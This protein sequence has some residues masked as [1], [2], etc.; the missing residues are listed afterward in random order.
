L[1]I[2]LHSVWETKFHTHMKQQVKLMGKTV[3]YENHIHEEIKSGLNSACA[4]YHSVQ[5]VSSFCLL[6]KYIK[7]KCCMQ[8]YRVSC[9]FV[10]KSRFLTCRKEH[11]LRVSGGS[12]ENI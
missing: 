8:N 11:R 5:N 9:C 6:S 12:E 2:I 7:I 1:S 10:W 4:C 3:K